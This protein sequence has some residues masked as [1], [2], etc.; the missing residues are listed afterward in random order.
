L[1]L[2]RDATRSIEVG[3]GIEA[4]QVTSAEQAT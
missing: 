2:S 3:D 4:E 1:T